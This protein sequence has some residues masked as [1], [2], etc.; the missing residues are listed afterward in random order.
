MLNPNYYEIQ[1]IGLNFR[2]SDLNCA[3]GTNQL[4]KIEKFII[5]RKKIV[6]RYDK[7]FSDLSDFLKPVKKFKF[8]NTSYHLYV[9]LIDFEK[10]GLTRAH[11]INQLKNRNIE[12]KFITLLYI[13]KKYMDFQKNLKGPKSIIKSA[14]HYL[15]SLN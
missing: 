8:C 12:F 5:K 14:Y 13:C 11:I 3:L 2:A 4:N 1:S 7:K 10:I 6:Q 9:V 15:Y